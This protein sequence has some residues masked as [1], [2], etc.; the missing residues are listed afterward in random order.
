MSRNLMN[1]NDNLLTGIEIIDREHRGIVD[2]INRVAPNLASMGNE[3]MRDCEPLC[4]QLMAYATSHFKTEEDL[5]ARYNV[6]SRVLSHHRESHSGFVEK[7]KDLA[8]RMAGGRGV[9]GSEFLS[10]L[11]GWL[12]SHI[13]GEDQTMARQIRAIDSGLSPERAYRE[14]GGY[15][16]SPSESAL[17]HVFIGLYT[18][19]IRKDED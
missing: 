9:T 1:W 8:G 3:R 12:L 10:F 17:T 18:Q 11:A 14:A 4:E 2:L 15:R 13:L 6:D 19:M 7:V 5:M 16:T